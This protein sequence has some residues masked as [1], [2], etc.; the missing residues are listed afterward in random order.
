[1]KKVV[2]FALVVACAAVGTWLLGWWAV[3]AIA[4]IAGLISCG[5]GLVA[6]AC[7]TAWLLLLVIDA[8]SGNI[9]HVAG[10]L[11]G[12]MGLPAVALFAVTLALPALLGWSAASLGDAARSIRSTSR[13]PSQAL[14]FR[15]RPGS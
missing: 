10:I 7:A 4:L 8:A 13:Q 12:V 11:A 6:G 1:M 14:P 3:P 2:C 15:Q 5:P 9:G